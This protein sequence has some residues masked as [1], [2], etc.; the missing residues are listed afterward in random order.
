[1][2]FK[3]GTRTSFKT[4]MKP[5]IKNKVVTTVNAT[6]FDVAGAVVTLGA[7]VELTFGIAI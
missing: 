1:M 3:C 6:L 2:D 5:H 7:D 4:V